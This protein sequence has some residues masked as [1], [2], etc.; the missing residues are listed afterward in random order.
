MHC[1][2]LPACQGS[3]LFSRLAA[4]RQSVQ[5]IGLA[6]RLLHQACIG[7]DQIISLILRVPIARKEKRWQQHEKQRH[8]VQGFFYVVANAFLHVLPVLCVQTK[9]RVIFTK[10]IE[11]LLSSDVEWPITRLR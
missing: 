10:P 6:D 7:G 8:I 11:C 4:I 5:P 3:S 1:C 2:S 9:Q